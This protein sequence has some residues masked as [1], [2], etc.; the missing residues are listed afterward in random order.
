MVFSKRIL[1]VQT[2]AEN[3]GAQEISRLLGEELIKR[4]HDVHHLFFYRKTDGFDGREN[5][6]ICYQERPS[7]PFQMLKLLIKLVS[8]IKAVKPDV[9]FTFQHFGNTVGAP[10]A[11]LAGVPHIVANQVS[12]REIIP[13][14]VR[15]IDLLFGLTGLYNAITVN[16]YDLLKDYS[17]FPKR[18]TDKTVLIPHGFEEKTSTLSKAKARVKF[19]IPKGVPLLG[20]VSRLNEAKQIDCAIRL[21]TDKPDWHLLIA[22]QGPDEQRLQQISK[23]LQVSERT[24]FVGEVDQKDVGDILKALDL[25][26]FTSRAETFGLAAVE[27]GQAGVPV[28]S[29]DLAVLR[30]ILNVDG[31]ATALFVDVTN[32]QAFA[33]VVGNIFKDKSTYA[34]LRRNG[35]LLKNKYS[36]DDMVDVYEKLATNETI[37]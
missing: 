34:Y 8:E 22:G 35:R 37:K 6:T 3:A 32:Q 26:V 4:G 31:K 18:Y 14:V 36:L 23:E 33:K 7:G 27:A 19:N 28:I 5:T 20:T 24:H 2:Q 10:A 13:P 12:A 15:Y 17:V 1:F 9:V 11:K 21:L 25:F 30:E 16:S 29:N